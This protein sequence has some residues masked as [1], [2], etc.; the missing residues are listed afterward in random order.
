MFEYEVLSK[1][2]AKNYSRMLEVL[3][4]YLSKDD[5]MITNLANVSALIN[6]YVDAIN[7]VGF[8]IY[9]G[10]IL[11]LG[12]FQGLPAC[13]RIELGR[14]VCGVA[15]KTGET[16]VVEDVHS[17]ENHITCDAASQSEIVVPIYHKGSLVAVLDIDSPI[18]KRFGTLE[19][20]TFEALVRAIVDKSL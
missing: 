17:I 9:D 14:G 4:H 16:Q 2:R 12:P 18:K 20:E 11:T 7:W 1:D 3:P 19:K 5:T 6:F 13:T 15:A 8:Y 10:S